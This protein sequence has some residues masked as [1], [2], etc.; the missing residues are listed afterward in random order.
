[1]HRSHGHPSP[2][3]R[4]ITEGPPPRRNKDTMRPHHLPVLLVLASPAAAI[5]LQTPH[6]ALAAYGAVRVQG[7][8]E[9][10]GDAGF[11]AASPGRALDL[12]ADGRG[13]MALPDV[14]GKLAL[15]R[16][17]SRVQLA[18]FP[19]SFQPPP[20]SNDSAG[21]AHDDGGFAIDADGRFVHR[22]R[23]PRGLWDACGRPGDYRLAVAGQPR[24]PAVDALED[25]V[26]NIS[27]IA[28]R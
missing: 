6:P 24:A 14:Y 3:H 22:A 13:G 7:A 9:A 26:R 21:M 25:C 2:P 28:L 23:N 19:L 20:G 15:R 8:D 1:M 16:V 10:A 5:L 12:V 27:L 11:Y 18:I 4:T 17:G